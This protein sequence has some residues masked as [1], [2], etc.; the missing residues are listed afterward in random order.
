M[1]SKTCDATSTAINKVTVES[2]CLILFIANA[3]LSF[4]FLWFFVSY[5]LYIRIIP[6]R[7]FTVKTFFAWYNQF[8]AGSNYL[9]TCGGLCEVAFC[10]R[11]L[12]KLVFGFREVVYGGE[13]AEDQAAEAV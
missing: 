7:F 13:Y 6:Y 8:C 3:F 4:L 10:G 2:K 12:S 5:F 9:V 1:G 11:M